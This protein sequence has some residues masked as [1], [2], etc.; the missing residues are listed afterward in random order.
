MLIF[1]LL[2]RQHL[3]K[4]LKNSLKQIESCLEKSADSFIK[5]RSYLEAQNLFASG[6]TTMA[7][8]SERFGN[9]VKSMAMRMAKMEEERVRKEAE[10]RVAADKK[11]SEAR[12]AEALQNPGTEAQGAEQ[13]SGNSNSNNNNT[14]EPKYGSSYKNQNYGGPKK[15]YGK[16][17]AYPNE[18]DKWE[19]GRGD[20][21]EET[22]VKKRD[23]KEIKN[24]GQWGD[25]VSGVMRKKKTSGVFD[26][27]KWGNQSHGGNGWVESGKTKRKKGRRKGKGRGHGRGKGTVRKWVET[28]E[29]VRD[30]EANRQNNEA[31]DSWGNLV[32]PKHNSQNQVDPGS[33]TTKLRNKDQ[34]VNGAGNINKSD[35][36]EK[37]NGCAPEPEQDKTATLVEADAKLLT[38]LAMLNLWTSEIS[39]NLTNQED[40]TN[41]SERLLTDKLTIN[42]S[43]NTGKANE[44]PNTHNSM[45]TTDPTENISPQ[46]KPEHKNNQPNNNN[47]SATTSNTEHTPLLTHTRDQPQATHNAL[48]PSTERGPGSHRS[49][50]NNS[51]PCQTLA[52]LSRREI[53]N[54]GRSSEMIS[55]IN[56][57]GLKSEPSQAR[58]G[59]AEGSG[60][61][62][63]ENVDRQMNNDICVMVSQLGECLRPEMLIP[64]PE[65]EPILL[66]D[67]LLDCQVLGE[68]ALFSVVDEGSAINIIQGFLN[69]KNH[70][71]K[72]LQELVQLA[73]EAWSAQG[74]RDV[75]KTWITEASDDHVDLFFKFFQTL[76]IS[77]PRLFRF[78]VGVVTTTCP[79]RL[80]SIHLMYRFI[81]KGFDIDRGHM[82]KLLG[83]WFDFC[84]D[85]PNGTELGLLKS[86]KNILVGFLIFAVPN[87]GCELSNLSLKVDRFCSENSELKDLLKMKEAIA[88]QRNAKHKRRKK[89]APGFT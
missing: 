83:A 73:F 84:L 47:T 17:E 34:N 15:P 23:L 6:E 61:F 52:R 18:A 79:V 41:T 20:R 3:D 67:Y 71:D 21:E 76:L 58:A 45:H 68:G 13:I 89:L 75:L 27:G 30:R 64:I 63:L 65:D 39:Q 29:S 70:S 46:D 5:N 60:G 31:R 2:P 7:R 74:D 77:N 4:Y 53:L 26:G 19:K 56:F 11:A 51:T 85:P 25:D 9:Q 50:L 22:Y 44:Q 88:N 35:G 78:G 54:S 40:S 12:K 33:G 62:I 80:F 16:I 10:D 87:G 72:T 86:K 82:D 43:L 37:E 42:T 59:P 66:E 38:E 48:S 69:A 8:W 36:N 24:I 14:G 55:N 28:T 32:K 49:I 1:D 81:K 57:G